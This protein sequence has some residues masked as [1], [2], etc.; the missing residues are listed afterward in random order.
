[1]KFLKIK[2]IKLKILLPLATIFIL[3]VSSVSF[4]SCF[5][6]N[7]LLD[8]N[9]KK[10]ATTK[11]E[12]ISSRVDGLLN[13]RIRIMEEL[14]RST[15]AKALDING[16]ERYIAARKAIAKDFEMFFVSDKSGNITSSTNQK[17]N[18]SDTDYFKTAMSGQSAIS[19]P[20][21]SKLSGNTV[22]IFAVPI[23]NENNNVAGLIAGTVKLASITDIINK[24]NINKGDYAYIIDKNGLTVSHPDKNKILKENIL[25]SK[26]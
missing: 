15:E 16:V 4:I 8:N 10:M 25:Q 20:L 24:T 12:E 5:K 19:K 1:M 23:T 14:S 11:A 2:S 7:S 9:L 6:S 3:G 26:Y 21:I 17:F 22:I 13:S 18:I